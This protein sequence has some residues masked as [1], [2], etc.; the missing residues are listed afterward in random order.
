[1]KRVLSL[2]ALLII[3]STS[4]VLP[5]SEAGAIFL[6]IAP[7]ARAGGMGEAQVALA[8]D[9]YASYWNPAGLGFLKGTE[10]GFM[11]VNWLPNL[12]DDIYYEFFAARHHIPMLGTIGGHLIFLNLGEQIRTDEENNQL[13]TFTSYMT[14]IT[15]S[16]STLLSP[17]SSIGLNAKVS[18]QHLAQ[19]GAGAEKGKGTS[20][21]FGFDIGYLNKAFISDRLTMGL[22]ITNIGPKVDFI[23]PAQGDPQPT[24]LTLGLNY[25][26][27]DSEFN[28][29]NIVYDLNKMLVAA[30]PDMD[31]D[32]DYHV[33]GYDKDGN[34]T[35]EGEY[36]KS[37]Q[38]EVV[39]KDPIY[40]AIFTSWLDDWLLGGDIDKATENDGSIRLIGGYDW[41]DLDGDNEV[42]DN[43]ITK[44]DD[45]EPGEEG[46]GKYNSA[47]QLEVGSGAQRTIMD[48]I[49][50]LIHK[51]GFEYWY[52]SYF[53]IRGGLI[54]DKTG[55][56]MN[57]TFGVGLRFADY[58][59]D[60]GY[61]SGKPGHPL[62]NTMRFSL[63]WVF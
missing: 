43:E 12:A 44:T 34:V 42:D 16:Y 17:K 6:L 15:G 30:Y 27:I 32:G 63:N 3:S 47:G 10:F 49:D 57:P 56:I 50:K 51:V 21:D 14:A 7:G 13:G 60:F 55:K 39:H 46:W 40:L 41:N 52:S 26:L 29:V 35:P 54:Y 33:G 62:T 9:A 25:R 48:E 2:F 8:D 61:I 11:H 28:K 18:Y 45:V 20:I 38:L 5:Q 19:I 59:F 1:M 31:W 22:T 58:G 53:A 24:N 23:D 4:V 37:G 36:N